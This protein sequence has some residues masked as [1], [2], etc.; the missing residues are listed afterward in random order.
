MCWKAPTVEAAGNLSSGHVI[1]VLHLK[2]YDHMDH[3][4]PC[5]GTSPDVPSA[6][7]IVKLVRRD[8]D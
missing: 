6:I 3:P 1:G 7:L 2:P 5:R 4:G 8:T